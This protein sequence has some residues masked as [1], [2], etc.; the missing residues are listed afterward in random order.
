LRQEEE[1]N[2]L[3]APTAEAIIEATEAIANADAPS[4]AMTLLTNRLTN[5]SRD[6]QLWKI[7][8][9]DRPSDCQPFQLGAKS[10]QGIKWPWVTS[11]PS[12]NEV[13]KVQ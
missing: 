10:S 1:R 6:C 5:S 12:L 13:V 3:V 9:G 7:E 11:L 2:V 4:E 8:S